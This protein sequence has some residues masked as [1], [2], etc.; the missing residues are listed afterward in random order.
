MAVVAFKALKAFFI[1]TE[2]HYKTYFRSYRVLLQ[3]FKRLFLVSFSSQ[4][5]IVF[6]APRLVTLF[7]SF[8]FVIVIIPIVT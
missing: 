3:F 2:V 7:S 6:P 1:S 4:L 8:P 5:V